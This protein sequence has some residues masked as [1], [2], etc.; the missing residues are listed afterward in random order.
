MRR[1]RDVELGAEIL[2]NP[3]SL[4]VYISATARNGW[5]QPLGEVAHAIGAGRAGIFQLLSHVSS[6]GL[7]EVMEHAAQ[8]QK[9]G[10]QLYMKPDRAVAEEEIK[11]AA[12]LGASSIWLTVDLT[13]VSAAFAW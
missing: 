6:K 8:G 2:G 1:V 9:I 10:W 4:P 3:M 12:R 11:E 5:V 13:T 7:D